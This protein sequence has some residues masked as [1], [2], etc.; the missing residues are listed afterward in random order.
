MLDRHELLRWMVEKLEYMKNSNEA[1][2]CLYL[3]LVIKVNSQL[4]FV[5]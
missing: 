5:E 3:Q 2:Q 4:L 1:G